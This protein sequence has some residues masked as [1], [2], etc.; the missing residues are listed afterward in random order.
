MANGRDDHRGAVDDFEQRDVSRVAER[1]DQLAQK[2][3]RACL[4]TREGR[5][6][7][8]CDAV[9]D[10]AKGSLGEAKIAAVPLQLAL[11]HEVIEPQ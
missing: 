5:C 2:R 10:R 11:K 9:F 3:A 1:N 4:S 6:A 8:C 7:Q